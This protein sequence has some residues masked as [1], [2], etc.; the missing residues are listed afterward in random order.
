M[1]VYEV[2]LKAPLK[3]GR[4]VKSDSLLAI[5]VKA[6]KSETL[7]GS[8]C[9]HSIPSICAQSRPQHFASWY[10]ASVNKLVNVNWDIVLFCAVVSET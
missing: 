10:K 8:H 6:V 2:H 4:K 5:Q 3:T 7:I 9:C 1:N